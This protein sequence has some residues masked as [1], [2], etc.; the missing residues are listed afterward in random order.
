[1]AV[2]GQLKE[3]RRDGVLEYEGHISTLST[4]LY[5]RLVENPYRSGENSPE[6]IVMAK[7]STGKEIEVGSA[8]KNIS[9]PKIIGDEGKEYLSIKIDDPSMPSA[10]NVSAFSSRDNPE[11]WNIV[12]SRPKK[13]EIEQAA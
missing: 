7:S 6:F 4:Q 1:M 3:T 12:W 13:Q 9:A 10:L 11:I 2:I 8:W 5:I